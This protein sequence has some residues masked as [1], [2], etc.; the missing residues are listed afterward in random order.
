MDSTALVYVHGLWLTGHE[1]FLLRRRLVRDRGYEWHSFTY[2]SQS[3][4]MDAVAKALAG[5]IK[6]LGAARVHLV[7]H[8]LG[9][10][11]ILRSLA[12][13]GPFPAGRVVLLGSPCVASSA[14]TRVARLRYGRTILGQIGSEELLGPKNRRWS[15]ERELGIIAGTQSLSIGRLVTDF[16]EP[17]D[18]TVAV[19]E[20][21]LPGASAHLTLPVSHTGMLLSA[22]VAR[23]TGSFLEHGRYG[24]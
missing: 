18:G 20:T 11:V 8:S 19:S 9:G 1:A 22:R 16:K 23:E 6:S 24:L 21:Q 7:G 17:N 5:H 13:H 4:S 2:R 15:G 10:L 12:E 3:G 14:A